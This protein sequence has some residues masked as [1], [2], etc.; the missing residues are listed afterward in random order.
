MA[1][2]GDY[3]DEIV[4]KWCPQDSNLDAKPLDGSVPCI[5][6]YSEHSLLLGQVR[7]ILEGPGVSLDHLNSGVC[8]R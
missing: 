1:S 2:F 5:L 3:A 8:C 4:L 6:S 7:F